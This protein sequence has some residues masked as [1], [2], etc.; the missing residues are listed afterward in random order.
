MSRGRRAWYAVIIFLA[1][2]LL[3]GLAATCR[4]RQVRGAEHLDR[5]QSEGGAAIISYW[6]Q[7]QIFCARYLL[8]R[9]RRGLKVS[10][11]T[12]PSVSGE[13]P[14]AIIRRWGAGV[15]R[16]SSK[17]SAGQALRDMYEVLVG[18]GTSLVITPDGPTGPLHEF[19]PGTI[20]LARM[21]RVPIIL[22]AY[23]AKPCIRWKSW[24]RFIVP[25]PFSKVA[26]A[27]DEPFRVPPGAGTDE[28][29]RFRE[30]LEARMAAL[31]AEVEAAV[32][33]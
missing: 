23:A 10:F 7:M 18:Q 8:G 1:R 30:Q 17:R 31:V 32:D 22:I 27:I 12:S 20:M 2:G 15:L 24:D 5:L 26:I 13:V 19:K 4:L 25:L 9:A 21:A 6:H 14:A 28:L 3:A 33:D 16:G 29:G 11:L